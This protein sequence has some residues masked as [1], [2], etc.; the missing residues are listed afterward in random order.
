[1]AARRKT[2]E[3][4][5]PVVLSD[6]VSWTRPGRG[7]SGPP[8]PSGPPREFTIELETPEGVKLRLTDDFSA[9][10]LVR[11]LAALRTAC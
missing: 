11:L 3:G 7:A 8:R 4:F 6:P 1:M 5:V 10:A 2:P 9:A